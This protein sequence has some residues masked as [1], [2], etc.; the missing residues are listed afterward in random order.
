M[1]SIIKRI[2]FAGTADRNRADFLRELLVEK[3]QVD[4][5]GGGYDKYLGRGYKNL[6]L[7][8]GVSGDLYLEKLQQ[9]F[10]S[11]NLYRKQNVGSHN[12][13]SFEIPAVGGIQLV[14]Y[15]DQMNELF[16]DQETVFF[17]RNEREMRGQIEDLLNMS[18][19]KI[20]QI[21]ENVRRR[22]LMSGY[23]YAN[24]AQ[25]MINTIMTII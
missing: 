11:L 12:M 24:R 13:R 14:E 7:F 4:V 15:S 23:S 16:K 25:E 6:N 10:I 1:G 21:K 18:D 8:P 5:Y 3:W 20:V 22:T 2:C 17:Y 9:Y 19:E